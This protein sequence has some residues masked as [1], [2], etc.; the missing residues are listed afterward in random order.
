MTQKIRIEK[1][2]LQAEKKKIKHL[3]GGLVTKTLDCSGEEKEG[4]PAPPLEL[5]LNGFSGKEGSEESKFESF[6]TLRTNF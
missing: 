1:T 6:E 5:K 3:E 2:E 4:A